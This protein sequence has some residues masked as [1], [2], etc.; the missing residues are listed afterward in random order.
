MHSSK[1]HAHISEILH[2]NR[3]V[4]VFGLLGVVIGAGLVHGM[5]VW[6]VPSVAPEAITAHEE[7]ATQPVRLRIPAVNIDTTFE[8]PIGLNADRSIEVPDSYE[9]VAYYKHGP[10]PGEQ[11]PAVILGHVD[12]YEGNAV[13][14]SLRWLTAGDMIYVDRADGTTV[15][16]EVTALE[17]HAQQGFPTEK[18]YGD[19][20][21]AGLRLVTCSGN[22]DHTAL[23]YS[24]NLIVFAAQQYSDADTQ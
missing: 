6:I 14:W 10:V 5:R 9:Q 16:F 15:T 17:D 23:R 13:F 4:L 11:G 24:H 2:R 1:L 21:H 8:S 3:Q 22:Y 18:V 12:S 19:L 7:A 20:D